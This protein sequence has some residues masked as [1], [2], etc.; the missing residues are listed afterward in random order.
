MSVLSG[1]TQKEP[2][3]SRL[4]LQSYSVTSLRCARR[5]LALLRQ[6]RSGRS[7]SFLRLTLTR[8]RPKQ[9]IIDNWQFSFSPSFIH[10]TCL[11]T[12]E[13]QRAAP[14][15]DVLHN[16]IT[17]NNIP[18]IFIVLFVVFSCR[19]GLEAQH[20]APLLAFPKLNGELIIK[21]IW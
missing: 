4:R 12:V 8:T 10:R 21:L 9:L 3:K 6:R 15:N 19:V 5:K 18:N 11:A 17:I 13:A 1:L 7:T 20:A 16:P 2:K 14:H